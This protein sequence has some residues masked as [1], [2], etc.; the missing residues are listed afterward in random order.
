MTNDRRQQDF[1]QRLSRISQE[2]GQSVSPDPSAPKRDIADFDYNV[3][4]ERHPIR[5]GLIWMLVI[6]AV[7]AGGYY[8]W[9]AMPQDLRDTL[10]SMVAPSGNIDDI[11]TSPEA[12]PETDAMSDQGPT[13]RSP[14]VLHA[15]TSPLMLNDVATQ[16]SLP[17][18]STAIGDI[19]PIVRNAQC[20]LRTPRDTEKI[21]GVRIEN[22][23]LPAPLYTFS[24]Q[25]LADQL[26]RHVEAVT[27]D[28]ADPTREIALSGQ[29]T[30]LDVFV[31]DTSAPLYLVLQNMGPGIVW[32]LHAAPNVEIAHVALIG[33]DFSGVANLQNSATVEGLLV[34]DF[35]PPYQYGADDAPRDCMIRPWRAPEP[36]WIGTQKSEAGSLLYQNQMYS[37]AKGYEA[38]NR[39]FTATLGVD[40]AANTVTA[41]DAAHVLLGPEPSEPVN[42]RPLAGSAI[43]LMETDHL[44]VGDTASRVAAAQRLHRE[45]LMAAIGGDIS[46]LDPSAMERDSQ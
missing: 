14:G 23:L 18:D 44:L 21:I 42:Y 29:K 12:I 19:I 31:T 27:Q 16:V 43:H 39:W 10:T 6:A 26:L 5:N 11:A 34:S 8:G 22:A 45:L 33:S 17:D 4:R 2:R 28:G 1:A 41:R 40:A 36:D 15:G 13:L 30:V 37:Y 46:A 25:Q 9:N 38:Y 24:N 3:P 7:G 35:L 32:N 20:N